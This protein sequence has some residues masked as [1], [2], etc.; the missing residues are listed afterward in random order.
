M[1][2]RAARTTA[3][4][5]VLARVASFAFGVTIKKVTLVPSANVA[6][7]AT[8]NSTVA[9]RNVGTTATGT[10]AVATLTLTTGNACTAN[11]GKDITLT[12]TNATITAG[13][14]LVIHRTKNSSGNAVPASTW[15][16]EYAVAPT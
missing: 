4:S 6:G 10:V 2:V 8:N 3:A 1:L 7:H 5:A 13:Q 12:A 11:V 9:L 14:G 15:V 16:I